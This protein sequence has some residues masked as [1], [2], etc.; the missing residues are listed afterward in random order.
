MR[1]RRVE[2]S[3]AGAERDDVGVITDE[4]HQLAHERGGLAAAARAVAG[5]HSGGE[6]P[7]KTRGAK[8]LKYPL[9]NTLA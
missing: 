9:E 8:Q 1:R 4:L 6:L 3:D 2:F 5:G 7:A